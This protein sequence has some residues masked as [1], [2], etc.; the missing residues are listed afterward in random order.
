MANLLSYDQL[1]LFCIGFGC[2]CITLKH[3]NLNSKDYTG[4]KEVILTFATC[5]SEFIII[6][7]NLLHFAVNFEDCLQS[8]KIKK[9]QL[10]PVKSVIR[11]AEKLIEKL[12]A[13]VIVF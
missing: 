13:F 6:N 1:R 10:K 4:T 8:R 2:F 5:L 9:L 12:P 3:T 11:T 7:Q